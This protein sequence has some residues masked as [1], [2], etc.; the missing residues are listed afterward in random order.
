MELHY[1]VIEDINDP[2]EL[3]RV[4][5]RVI[6]VH[7]RDKNLIPTAALPWAIVMAGTN[8]PGISGLGH[9][10]F[11]V[12]GSWVV[13]T[14]T[15]NDLQAFMVMG[16][17]PSV[18]NKEEMPVSFG[19]TDPDGIYPKEVSTPDNNIRVR[20][21]DTPYIKEKDEAYEY[22]RVEMVPLYDS[23]GAEVDK[24]YYYKGDSR[25]TL[26]PPT[27]YAPV[28]PTN[29]V[30]E[31]ES[32]HIKEYDD[33]PGSER[34]HERHKSGSSYEIEPNGS[35][36]ERVVNN[37]YKVVFG[38]DTLEVTGNVRIIVSGNANIT[39]LQDSKIDVKGDVDLDVGGN[40][41]T[42]VQG[43]YEVESKGNMKFTAP[44]I[45]IN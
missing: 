30:Y 31:T 38:H 20:D 28:Y 11:L 23:E 19:F 33:T 34:I 13:G 41:D 27:M 4:K 6:N 17:L 45:D 29:N 35:K 2:K 7:S 37:N 16:T 32:G 14:F 36:I 43:T 42:L 10:T 25:Q 9:S 3:G 39:V 15:D 22:G 40:M 8:T 26:Q 24:G 21:T 18:S 12:Q 5:V 44:H 1:G